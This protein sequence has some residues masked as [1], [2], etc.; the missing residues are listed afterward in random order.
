MLRTVG[1]T[2]TF[3]AQRALDDVSLTL[4][5]GTVTGLVGEN[6]AGKSTIL[7]V[8]CGITQPDGGEML[9][10]NAPIS[11]NGY[12]A[13]NHLGI[14]RVFQ[15]PALIGGI[16]LYE[17][18]FLGHEK[19]F[20]RR[21]IVN[22]SRMIKVAQRIVADFG[23]DVDVRRTTSDFSYPVRQSAE[24]VKAAA[25]PEALG[26]PR[27]FVLFDE[28]T[29][30][31][32][33]EEVPYLL[34]LVKEL[35]ARGL[36]VAFVSH[37]LNEV[38]EICRDIAVL[39]DGVLVAHTTAS[40]TSEAGLHELMVGRIRH[41][42]FHAENRQGTGLRESI[43]LSVREFGQRA[44]AQGNRTDAS[45]YLFKDVSFE[46]RE[47]EILGI[48]GLIGSGKSALARCIAGVGRPDEGDVVLDGAPVRRVST[49]RMKRNGV[50]YLSPDR[51]HEGLI[52]TDPVK[53]SI[54]LPS[55]D[56]D[57]HG[58]VYR[59]GIWKE[60]LER[61]EAVAAIE[62]YRIKAT[63]GMT[64]WQLSGGNQ[65]KVAL[66]KWTRRNPRVLVV[67]NPTAAVDV[68]AKGDIYVILRELAENGTSV[69]L[70][71]DDLPEVIGL[72][73]R[74]LVMRNGRL[75]ETIESPAGSKPDE[76]YVLARM[77]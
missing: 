11:P 33:H 70:V 46:L 1:I 26:L 66:A 4:E 60:R 38:L 58:F 10:D 68:G 57:E 28:P 65:Q 71:G 5:R 36:G 27:A 3:D 25:V 54:S 62:R 30:G 35:A 32:S 53:W 72:S 77:T 44:T 76:A 19:A 40:E 48:T 63:P 42:D 52:Q 6:G 9:L 21:G 61:R 51:R 59:G 2:K 56:R 29:A 69:L 49:V 12:R 13:A 64:T 15:E 45:R 34:G 14:W 67:E 23:I 17:N 37:R 7:N 31:L 18:L 47:G 43:I 73:D 39:K 24:A 20:S 22:H 41:A 50:V 75:A 8:L 74:I 55:G 16:P